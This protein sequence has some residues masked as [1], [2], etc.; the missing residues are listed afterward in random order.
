MSYKVLIPTAGIGSRLGSKTKFLNKSLISINNKP[1]I[2]HIIEIFPKDV[3]YVFALGYRGNLVKEYIEFA[4]PNI[5]KDFQLINPFIGEGSGLGYTI[6]CCKKYLKEPFTFYPC[7]ALIKKVDLSPSENWIGYNNE[8]INK[9]YRSI[10]IQNNIV[11]NI[12]EKGEKIEGKCFPYIGVAGINDFESFWDNMKEN[13]EKAI[14]EGEVY[15]LKKILNNGFEPRRFNWFDIGNLEKLEETR[16]IFDD[17]E[18]TILEKENE[19]IWFHNE[20]VVKFSDDKKFISNRIKRVEFLKDFVPD[21][22]D[23]GNNMYTYKKIE[24]EV[25]SRKI[26]QTNFKDFLEFSKNLWQKVNINDQKEKENF[27]QICWK[28]YKEKTIERIKMFIFKNKWAENNL[29][30]NNQYVGNIFDLFSKIDW[31]DICDGIPSRFHGDYHFENIIF[32]SSS[33]TFT[34]VDWRQDFGGILEYGDIYYDLAKLMHG[35]IIS[36]KIIELDLYKVEIKDNKIDFDF[37]RLDSLIF[38]QRILN[39]W[40]INNRYS[41][42]KVNILTALIFINSS[43]LHHQPYGSLLYALGIRNLYDELN[44]E[45]KNDI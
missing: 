19:A 28:F 10:V 42:K 39:S 20:K 24:G 11:T 4:H 16:K 40:I 8:E 38:L 13:N 17:K 5:K 22:I 31:D 14:L 43:P 12:L 41:I 34:C 9:N 32:N 30:I 18:I 1:I 36:H 25:L 29:I 23:V 7:D 15:G 3:H 33:K 45:S 21:I 6:M 44:E 37:H 2:S 27:K 35:L 26:N